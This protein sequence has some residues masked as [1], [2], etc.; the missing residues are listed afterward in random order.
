MRDRVYTGGSPFTLFGP[1]ARRQFLNRTFLLVPHQLP[2]FTCPSSPTT[3]LDAWSS[4]RA[5]RT[6][7]MAPAGTSR[8]LPTSPSP[9]S[10]AMPE[11]LHAAHRGR[12]QSPKGLRKV[13]RKALRRVLRAS[14]LPPCQIDRSDRTRSR[15][16]EP[17]AKSFTLRSAGRGSRQP[18]PP[19]GREPGA[20]L[21][22]TNQRVT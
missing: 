12:A 10:V 19:S 18:T 15:Q 16:P 21:D 22:A 1:S 20:R 4:A 17:P 8:S 2:L 5:S 14:R 11:P 9:V 7:L 6:R 13:L 3:S